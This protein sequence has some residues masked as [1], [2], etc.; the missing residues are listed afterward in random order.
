[1][2]PHTRLPAGKKISACPGWLEL[3]ADRLSFIFVQQKAETVKKIFDLSIGGLG[4]YSIAGHLN[5][6][7][8]PAFGTSPKWDH[9]T[10]DSMLRNKAT[11]G[12]YQPKS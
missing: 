9:T 8:I 1:M 7:G 10:I 6:Q 5:R 12:E 2:S 3:S 11:F 4:S